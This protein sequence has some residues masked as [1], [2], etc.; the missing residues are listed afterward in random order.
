MVSGRE[1]LLI[2]LFLL[3]SSVNLE[4]GIVGEKLLDLPLILLHSPT[5]L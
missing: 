2:I 1:A 3:S 4:I 5:T